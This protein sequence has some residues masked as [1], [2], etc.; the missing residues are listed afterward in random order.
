MSFILF[1][2]DMQSFEQLSGLYE[3]AIEAFVAMTPQEIKTLK[4]AIFQARPK[5]RKV[6]TD[7]STRTRMRAAPVA[8]HKVDA[9]SIRGKE[10]QSNHY[11]NCTIEA[12]LVKGFDMLEFKSPAPATLVSTSDVSI[13]IYHIYIYLTL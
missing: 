9:K 13:F 1:S 7:G 12:L 2:F 8:A 3:S 11:M 10:F 5:K 4:D 6:R